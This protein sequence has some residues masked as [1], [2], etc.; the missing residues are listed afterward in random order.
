VRSRKSSESVPSNLPP[1]IPI[2]GMGG[3]DAV[4]SDP[5]IRRV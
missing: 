2:G 5:K 3:I 1:K 4:I